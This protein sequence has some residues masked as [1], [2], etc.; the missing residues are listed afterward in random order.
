MRALPVLVLVAAP[1]TFAQA[2]D[3]SE[4]VEQAISATTDLEM[5]SAQ[6]GN[7]II[8][9]AAL[10]A[11]DA[12]ANAAEALK[13][14]PYYRPPAVMDPITFK[15]FFDELRRGISGD[16][17]ASIASAAHGHLF[18]VDQVISLMNLFSMGDDRIRVALTLY[19]R[20]ADSENFD[21]VYGTLSFDSD[22]HKLALAVA[23]RR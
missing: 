14:S 23:L 17:H 11:N 8:A 4:A 9:D 18:T 21:R 2:L 13:A 19:P 3:P 20:V 6:S 5:A 10:R 16:R 22:R 12:L 7:P 15:T 1:V